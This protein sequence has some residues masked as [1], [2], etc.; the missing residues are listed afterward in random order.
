M[1]VFESPCAAK[2]FQVAMVSENR[3]KAWVDCHDV[4][5]GLPLHLYRR[6]LCLPQTH[7]QDPGDAVWVQWRNVP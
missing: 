3:G 7:I 6:H 2:V 4:V 1:S 5:K